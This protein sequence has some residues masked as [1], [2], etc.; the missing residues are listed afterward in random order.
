MALYN[1]LRDARTFVP[2][3]HLVQV[4]R[5]SRQP[6]KAWAP[7]QRTREKGMA[8]RGCS[9][10]GRSEPL[11]TRQKGRVRLIRLGL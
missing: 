1:L 7:G 3:P 4:M 10:H 9:V 11:Y 8:R 5:C 2:W 6:L